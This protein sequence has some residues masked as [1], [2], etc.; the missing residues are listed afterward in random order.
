MSDGLFPMT[1]ESP[2]RVYS[3]P[4]AVACAGRETPM[5]FQWPSIFPPAGGRW[6][7]APEGGRRSCG[8][9]VHAVPGAASPPGGSAIRIGAPVCLR[10]VV[11]HYPHGR[12]RRRGSHPTLR[13]ARASR[14]ETGLFTAGLFTAGRLARPS[15]RNPGNHPYRPG[16]V[17]LTESQRQK[18]R[19][20]PLFSGTWDADHGISVPGSG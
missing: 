18:S 15:V 16:F 14:P 1:G 20:K 8:V 6:R 13:N 9:R 12:P 11:A 17:T 7:I 4:R 2:F 19:T 10:R 3:V 5:R